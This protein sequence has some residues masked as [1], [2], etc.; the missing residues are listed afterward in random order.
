MSPRKKADNTLHIAILGFFVDKPNYGYDLFKSITK[1][2]S[3]NSI[4]HLKQSQFYAILDH[5]YQEDCLEIELQ[6]G[7]NYPDRKEYRL[8]RLGEQKFYNWVISPVHHGREMRQEFLAK[9]YFALKMS[10][11]KALVL[12]GNQKEECSDWIN[13]HQEKISGV[14]SFFGDLMIDYR[15]IQMQGMLEWL[16]TVEEKIR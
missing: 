14:D 1:D 9:L 11:D 3:F 7:G 6:D 5:Y 8:T 10:K 4:W 13:K 2:S 12:L 16:K 15:I